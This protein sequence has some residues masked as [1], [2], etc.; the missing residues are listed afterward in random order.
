MQIHELTQPR[1]SQLDEIQMFG[2]GGLGNLIGQTIRNPRSF[3]PGANAQKQADQAEY[4]RRAAKAAGKIQ[5]QLPE[6]PTLD[7][8]LAK[9]KAN[10]Q[11]QQWINSITAQWPAV[12]KQLANITPAPVTTKTTTATTAPDQTVTLGGKKLD[13]KNPN[14]AQVLAAM[15]KQGIKEAPEY[16]TPGG[17]VIPGGSKTDQTP[18][19]SP[20]ADQAYA[21]GFRQWVNSQLRTTRLDTL[22]SDP[23]LKAKLEPLLRQIVAARDNPQAQQ[24]LVHDFFSYAVAANHVVQAKN[25][26]QNQNNKSN[27]ATGSQIAGNQKVFDTGLNKG[28]LLNLYQLAQAAGGPAPR[29]TG[30]DFYDS[31]IAQIRGG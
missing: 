25:P 8:A 18:A 1:R 3:L 14:D 17:I 10:P 12:S 2:P 31:L 13:P 21:A 20:N 24:K 7:Q 5:A 23:E 22:E 29:S 11:A 27:L 26:G 6:P 9:L 19:V 15:A 4:A 30:N 16:T 28:Q